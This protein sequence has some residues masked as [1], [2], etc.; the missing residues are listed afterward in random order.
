ME[1]GKRVGT[2][3]VWHADGGVSWQGDYLKGKAEGE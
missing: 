3:T 2:W 1:Q